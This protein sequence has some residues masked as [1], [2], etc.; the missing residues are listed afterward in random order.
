MYLSRQVFLVL[1]LSKSGKAAAEFLLARNAFVYV[2]DDL[3]GERIEQTMGEL[4]KKGARRVKKED[5]SRMPEVCDVLV[6]SPGIPIDHA[7]AVAFKRAGRAVIGETELAARYMHAPVIAVTGTNGKTTTVSMLTEVLKK[8]G[9]HA[10][11]CGNIGTPMVA[12]CVDNSMDMAVAEISSFQLET[13]Q[14]LRPHVA[15]VLNI[16]EDHLNRHYNMENYIFLKAKL[17]KNST[18]AEY[19]VLNYDDATVRGFAAKTKARTVY[20]SVRERI[21]GAF[22]DSGTLYFGKEK[23][24]SVSDLPIGGVHNVQNALA[25]IAAA[26]IM[27]VKNEDIAS[28]L[29]DFKGIK[30]RIETVG[31][32][33]GVTFV[34]DSKGTNVDATIKAIEAMKQPTVLLLGGKNKGYDYKKL[35]SVITQS[36]VVHAVLYGENRF[37]LLKSAR[38]SGFERITLCEDFSFAVRIAAWKAESGQ[39]VLLS[40][41]SASFD[42]F[43]NYEERGDK[44]V[45][46]VHMLAP[47]Q[48]ETRQEVESEVQSTNGAETGEGEESGGLDYGLEDAVCIDGECGETE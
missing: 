1:G 40:P 5:L 14:S 28:A 27:G 15:V 2:Y 20:F 23:I 16:T 31:E 8:G 45:E 24:L 43:A 26:K 13:L 12:F 7:L 10:Q 21:N 41:A 32:I 37:A 19:A 3:L 47:K 46:I 33:D 44:F 42:E 48:E 6:L 29:R 25:V 9:F 30:H 39:T 36:Q 35:F 22:Y 34:D 17:L 38:E 11:S 18:E 4:E